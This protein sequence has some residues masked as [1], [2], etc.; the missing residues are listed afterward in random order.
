[1][2]FFFLPALLASTAAAD[3]PVKMPSTM[4]G[5]YEADAALCQIPW[6]ARDDSEEDGQGSGLVVIEE[7]QIYFAEWLWPVSSMHSTDENSVSVKLLNDVDGDGKKFELVEK[8]LVLLG[9]VL[10]MSDSGGA[11]YYYR[12]PE[13]SKEKAVG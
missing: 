11:S 1:V 13:S 4:V 7:R 8:H 10:T 12:C 3:A 2:S 9:N 6:S 5:R